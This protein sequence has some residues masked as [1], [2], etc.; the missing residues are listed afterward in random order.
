M[1]GEQSTTPGRLEAIQGGFVN[2]RFTVASAGRVLGLLADVAAAPRRRPRR[3]QRI[4]AAGRSRRSQDAAPPSRTEPALVAA[5]SRPPIAGPTARERFMFTEPS[6]IACGRS[7][8]GTSSGWSVCHVGEVQACPAPRANTSASSTTGVTSPARA[9]TPNA[10]TASSMNVCATSRKRDSLA[11]ANADAKDAV[12]GF[13]QANESVNQQDGSPSGRLDESTVDDVV[14]AGDVADPLGG[15]H[16]DEGRY[17]FP[18]RLPG[19]D[20]KRLICR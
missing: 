5:T 16:R 9:S 2:E 12:A 14:H 4:R 20:P 11:G 7:A 8:A 18:L 10:S 6:A 1:T 17:P 19:S 13:M 15:Q 3:P